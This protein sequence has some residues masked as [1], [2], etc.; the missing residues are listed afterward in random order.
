MF[1]SSSECTNRIVAR[2][3][4]RSRVLFGPD[5]AICSNVVRWIVS[6]VSS[7]LSVCFHLSRRLTTALHGD[8]FEPGILTQPLAAPEPGW[9]SAAIGGVGCSAATSFRSSPQ[10]TQATRFRF[11]HRHFGQ[12]FHS[13]MVLVGSCRRSFKTARHRNRMRRAWVSLP[14]TILRRRRLCVPRRIPACQWP[15]PPWP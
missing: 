15:H 13:L 2:A 6:T 9:A 10:S 4:L 8:A 1:F 3:F 12:C 7:R 14:A 5:V 11:M